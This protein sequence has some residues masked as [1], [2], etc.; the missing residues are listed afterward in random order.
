MPHI[1]NYKAV[2]RVVLLHSSK[3]VQKIHKIIHSIEL[4]L[5]ALKLLHF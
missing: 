1:Q 5:T 4:Y 3:L 2:N